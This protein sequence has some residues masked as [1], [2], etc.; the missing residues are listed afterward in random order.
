MFV[1]DFKGNDPGWVYR[2][3]DWI[4]FKRFNS[5]SAQPSLNRNYLKNIPVLVPNIP[6]QRAIAELLGALDEKI[7]ANTSLMSLIDELAGLLVCGNMSSATI[8]L[9]SIA[10]IT[11]GSSPPGDT[12]NESSDGVV[13]YQGNRDFGLRYPVNRLWTTDPQRMALAGDTLVSVRAPVGQLNIANESICIGRGLAAVRS[14]T[15]LPNVLFHMLKQSPH[16]WASYQAE[17]T[18][19]GSINKVQMDKLPVPD[20]KGEPVQLESDV[21]SLE[22]ALASANRENLA[23]VAL[24]DLLLPQLMSGKLRVK[25]AEKQLE[26]VV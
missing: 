17:G 1:T 22:S 13:F 15:G 9:A 5:G 12:F 26:D 20:I 6:E 21:A 18:V 2:L 8:P 19:F 7:A 23:L 3:L 11:M 24:R 4:D 14:T 10:T 16:V 25:D